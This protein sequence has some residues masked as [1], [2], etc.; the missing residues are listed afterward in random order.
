MSLVWLMSF[1]D[2]LWQSTLFASIAGVLTLAL[3]G[4]GARVRHWIWV[5]ASWKFLIPIAMLTA[6]EVVP[7]HTTAAP[8]YPNFFMVIEEVTGHFRLPM[9]RCPRRR[10]RLRTN[11]GRAHRFGCVEFSACH[12]PGSF[13]GGR[14]IRLAV[15][16]GKPT[17]VGIPIRAI[18]SPTLLGA[19]VF[20]I[21]RPVLLLPEGILIV[22]HG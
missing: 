12:S 20:G 8:V 17:D 15:Q 9:S 2:H 1:A 16:A 22:Y 21:R 3:R 6:L 11:A 14:R 4:N 7:W 19:S 13:A 10:S 5:A 18:S